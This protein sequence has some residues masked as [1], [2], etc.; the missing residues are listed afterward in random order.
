MLKMLGEDGIGLSDDHWSELA[1]MT[2]GYVLADL[3]LMINKT[4]RALDQNGLDCIE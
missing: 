3:A 1:R 2:P 4:R